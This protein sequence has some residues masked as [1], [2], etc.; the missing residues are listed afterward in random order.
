MFYPTQFY[1]GENEDEYRTREYKKKKRRLCWQNECLAIETKVPIVSRKNS[2][3][4]V[5]KLK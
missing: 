3:G 5:Q 1:K 4:M 2:R